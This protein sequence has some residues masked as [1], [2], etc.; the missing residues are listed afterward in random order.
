MILDN[1]CVNILQQ[2][3]QAEGYVSINQL[4][5][6]IQVSKR[7]IYYDIKKIEDWLQEEGLHSIE[8]IRPLGYCISNE[9]KQMI[10]KKLNEF[11]SNQYEYSP[12]ERKIWLILYLLIKENRILLEDLIDL[13]QVSRNTVL[14]DLKKAKSRTK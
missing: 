2:I 1:R 9:T 12:Q 6:V 13:L 11:T 4:I 3:I 14:T 10:V 5:D 7:T 8:Y